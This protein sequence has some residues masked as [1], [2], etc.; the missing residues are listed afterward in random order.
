MFRRLVETARR[1]ATRATKKEGD[2]PPI[3]NSAEQGAQKHPDGSAAGAPET[4]TADPYRR[5]Q[6]DGSEDEIVVDE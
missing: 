2:N 1:N 6:Q 4:V 3:A 5:K